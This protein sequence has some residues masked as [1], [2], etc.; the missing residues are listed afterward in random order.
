[1]KK[2]L[3]HFLRVFIVTSYY[4]LVAFPLVVSAAVTLAWDSNDP[5][6]QGYN[7]FQRTDG[8]AYDYAAPINTEPIITTTYHVNNL[9][10]GETYYFVVQ[11]FSGS[12]QSSDSNEVAYSE[13]DT[14]NDRDGDGIEDALDAFPDDPNEWV[15][16]DGD[17]VGNNQDPDDDGDGM[18]D[19]Y[20]LQ[21]NGLDPLVD[22]A[23]GDLDGD[24]VSNREEYDNGTD[25]SQKTNYL[26]SR[27]NLYAPAEGATVALAPTLVIQEFFDANGDSHA[28]TRYQIA[29][30]SNFTYLVFDRQTG[31]D[32]ISLSLMDLILDPDT[33]YYWRA[34]FVDDQGGASDWSLPSSFVTLDYAAAG[35]EDANGILDS[36]EI[37][38]MRIDMDGDRVADAIQSDM[39]CVHTT[40]HINPQVGVKAGSAGVQIGAVRAMV[41]ED[42]GQALSLGPSDTLT[43]LISAKLYLDSGTTGSADIVVYVTTEAP[44]DAQYYYF[45]ED[46][47]QA[48]SNVEFSADRRSVTLTLEDGGEGDQDGVKNGV[49]V[50]PA[51]LGYSSQSGG[52]S[53]STDITEQTT[54]FIGT[55]FSQSNNRELPRRSALIWILMGLCGPVILSRL[56]KSQ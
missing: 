14:P 50:S 34:L 16:T 48:Y 20:E 56:R 45:A 42:M 6:P 51:A 49:I 28:Q 5:S 15:D 7:L 53:D 36:Q 39:L 26:P 13:P 11:A 35:D 8:Q 12:D 10:P 47:W 22:D 31:I 21:I 41:L 1:M 23:H 40:D 43:G 2:R 18:P 37:S 38:D 55:S 9:Q 52:S 32:L 3:C 19:S 30:D 24:N 44:D 25:P 33:I 27:P 4:L 17:G 29:L 46:D 54:C